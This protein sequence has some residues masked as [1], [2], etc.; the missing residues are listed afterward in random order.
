MVIY[1]ELEHK[2]AGHDGTMT[3]EDGLLIFKPLNPQELAFYKNIQTRLEKPK[4]FEEGDVPLELWMPTYLGLLEEGVNKPTDNAQIITD[5]SDLSKSTVALRGLGL[6][7]NSDGEDHKGF[8]V[9]EN[10]IAGYHKPN[11]MDIKLGKIL[12][13]ENASEEKKARLSKVSE[14]TTS[15][16]LGFRICGMKIQENKY[17]MDLDLQ[18]HEKHT[19]D[20]YIFVNKMFGRTRTVEDVHQAFDMYFSN[21]K[22]SEPRIEQLKHNFSQR[23]QLLYNTLLNEEVR[24]ISSS[25]LFVYE[26]DPMRWDEENDEDPIINDQFGDCSGDESSLATDF[27]TEDTP[28]RSPPLSSLSLIDFAHSQLTPGK[29]YDENVIEGIES[30]MDI[31]DKSFT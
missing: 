22:L 28:V 2:A 16:L 21:Q 15:G 19:D 1:K 17:T 11:I 18:H 6:D 30:L 31:F 9:L 7:E 4:R 24:M 3:D 5:G 8:L 12:Y 25:L 14:T 20:G 23:L 10:L 29:G 13:D 26:G 27:D